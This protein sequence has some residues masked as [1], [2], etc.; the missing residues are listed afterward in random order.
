MSIIGSLKS[1]AGAAVVAA[2]ALSTGGEVDAQ[3]VG[4][5]GNP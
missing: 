5:F 3:S 2:A 1:V 4:L